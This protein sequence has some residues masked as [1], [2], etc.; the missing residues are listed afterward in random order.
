MEARLIRISASSRHRDQGDRKVAANV[1]ER[2][3]DRLTDGRSGTC[4]GRG[5][6]PSNALLKT[7]EV[8]MTFEERIEKLTER[9]EALA[10]TV[11]LMGHRLNTIIE[12]I[13]KD[14]DNIRGLARIAELHEAVS[15]DSKRTTKGR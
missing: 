1:G 4:L 10:Q 14:A 12:A 9:H 11:G 8:N 5:T 13:N 6:H 2:K 3:K 15:K 7:F